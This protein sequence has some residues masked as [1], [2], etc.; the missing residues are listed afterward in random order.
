M[1]LIRMSS[2]RIGIP[3]PTLEI[4]NAAVCNPGITVELEP[5]EVSGGG[6]EDRKKVK[7]LGSSL[8]PRPS[9]APVFDCLQY[10]KTESE[11]LVNLTT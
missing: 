1:K 3:T 8:I 6:R 10:A 11:G 9:L 4:T 2:R 5:G 7:L